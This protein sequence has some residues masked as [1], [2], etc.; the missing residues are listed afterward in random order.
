MLI[1]APSTHAAE[2]TSLSTLYWCMNRTGNQFQLKAA[3][4]CEPL[5]E[6]TKST[7]REDAD[8]SA[9][10]TPTIA[11]LETAVS[12][13]LG[14]YQGLLR[15]CANDVSSIE[16]VT[17]LEA[18]ASALIANAVGKLS[19]AAFLVARNQA[20]VIPIAEARTKLRLLHDR[21]KQLNTFREQVGGLDYEQSS[22]ERRLLQESEDSISRDFTPTRH[23]SRAL[24]GTD[25]GKTGTS[26][27]NIGHSA[28]SGPEIGAASSTGSNIG[29]TPPTL[30]EMSETTPFNRPATSLGTTE[31]VIRGKVGRE[32]GSTPRTGES[33]GN[34]TLNEP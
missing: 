18:Q 23:P 25:I 20:L 17:R 13:F 33:I 15:C 1:P 11:N 8:D 31:P 9:R 7:S 22:K 27:V 28:T 34:S 32:I 26:G 12:A 29:A 19:P 6:S 30:E 16:D 24:S 10:I 14:E 2:T 4:D 3:P 21:L 5:V